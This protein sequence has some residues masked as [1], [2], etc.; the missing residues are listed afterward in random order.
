MTTAL[1][2]FSDGTPVPMDGKYHVDPCYPHIS[3]KYL[4][5]WYPPGVSEFLSGGNTARLGLLPDGTILKY[6]RDRDDPWAL[7]SLDVERQIFLALGKHERLAR[8]CGRQEHG[9][10]F[11]F[12]ANGD[13]RHYF[14]KVGSKTSL[15]CNARDGQNRQQRALNSF[16]QKASSTVIFTR[17]T[18]LLT[19]S[20]TFGFATLRAPCLAN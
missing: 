4:E 10:I 9:L 8:Y 6:V 5:P 12:E 19:T 13:L 14:S 11:Q 20:V 17:T 7:K 16:T 15:C 18:F 2:T 3:V 1:V